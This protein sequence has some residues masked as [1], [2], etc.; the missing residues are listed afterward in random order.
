MGWK[1]K[2]LNS[3][4]C[5]IF[6]AIQTN[7]KSQPDSCTMV[8]GSL[9]EVKLLEHGA[10][11]PPLSRAELQIGLSYTFASTLLLRR[12]IMG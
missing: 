9:P 1:A 10:D 12:Y 6:R 5:E 8:T 2:G 11:H 4:G 7:P 3:R